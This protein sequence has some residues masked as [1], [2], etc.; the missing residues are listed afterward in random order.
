MTHVKDRPEQTAE[1]REVV[2]RAQDVGVCFR[3]DARDDFRSWILNFL[4]GRRRRSAPIQALKDV[5]FEGLSGEVLG[6]IG[7]NG[8]GKTTLCSVI[9]RVLRPDAG[10]I[11]VRGEVSA[12]LSMGTG[13]NGDLTGK[14]NVMLNGLMLGFTR[15][16][17]R[18][19]YGDI[20]EFAGLGEFM[21]V[22][23]KHYSSGMKS[24][25][26]FSIASM[27]EPET[28]VLDE[29]LG[30]GD[31]EFVERASKRLRDLVRTARIVVVVTH[32]LQFIRDACERAIWIDGGV[33]MADG[34]SEDVATAYEASIAPRQSKRILTI[35]YEAPET[36]VSSKVV[37]R[38][39]NVTVRFRINRKPFVAL[40]E[41][42]FA[43]H[44]G[45]ILGIIGPN[46]AGKTTLCRVLSGI[47]RPDEGDV[48]VSRRV[49]A[50]LSM[51]T[52]F[53]K[54][55]DAVGNIMLNGL[56]LGIPKKD[57]VRSID[58]IL[59]FA[60]LQK[61]RNR[62]IKHFSKGMKARL[63]FSIAVAAHPALLIVD[64]ALSA[65]DLSFKD[66]A[67]E[68]MDEMIADADAVVVVSHNL[69]F[70]EKVCTRAVW[71]DHGRV[72]FDGEPADAVGRYSIA[73]KK[74]HS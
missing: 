32:N 53:N 57:L 6:I 70:I 39:D 15:R 69:R 31:A 17:M 67:T 37:A 22:P 35:D 42:S 36:E 71:L 44:H 26:G 16:Q 25:L 55:L 60:E 28:L 3:R 7:S 48:E 61:H 65:G 43:V 27:L 18:R 20:A 14:E 2:V 64:E 50:L 46:G 72:Q 47:Y 74:K 19:F 13:F 52:G 30:G 11:D 68:A 10:T 33:V 38:V 41:V 54:D 62:P 58:G 23:V 29:A 4:H 73:A 51:G 1:P 63:A 9:G 24:R 8:A 45:D 40:D 12:L 66:K 34:P 56:M 49:S 59:D 21:T 5:S